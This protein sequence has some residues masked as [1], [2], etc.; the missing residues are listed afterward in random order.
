MSTIFTKTITELKLLLQAEALATP[1]RAYLI[2]ALQ[3]R[4]NIISYGY[5]QTKS[6]PFQRTFAPNPHAIFFHAETACIHNALRSNF[7]K[8]DKATLYVVRLKYT[9]SDKTT[10]V[11][12]MA[13]PCTGCLACAKHYGVGQ[14]V[15]T[16]EETSTYGL[17]AL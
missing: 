9:S 1:R 6:H 14:I 8:F 17:V 13:R 7:T 12:A 10:L 2:S 3:H 16:T 4:G 5:N 15:Y 11:E